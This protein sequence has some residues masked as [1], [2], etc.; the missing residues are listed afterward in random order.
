MPNFNE[1]RSDHF[2]LQANLWN[3][4]S[5]SCFTP[6][7]PN[8]CVWGSTNIRGNSA[9]QPRGDIWIRYLLLSFCTHSYFLTQIYNDDIKVYG[10]LECKKFLPALFLPFHTEIVWPDLADS[11]SDMHDKWLHNLSLWPKVQE[12]H[13]IPVVE[14]IWMQI[15]RHL[16]NIDNEKSSLV[17]RHMAYDP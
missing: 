3:R 16:Q 13:L 4:H 14:I 7:R 6:P 2:W 8:P 12:C 11:A 10:L 9:Q 1:I 5:H 17:L 15:D